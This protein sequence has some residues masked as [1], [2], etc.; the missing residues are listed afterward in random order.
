[1]MKEDKEINCLM[2]LIINIMDSRNYKFIRFCHAELLF[3]RHVKFNYFGLVY[4]L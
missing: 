3:I 2:L 4:F 1:M